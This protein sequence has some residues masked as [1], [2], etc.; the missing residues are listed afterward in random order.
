M[1][2]IYSDGAK[3]IAYRPFKVHGQW[4]G[5]P[6]S[7][8]LFSK[9]TPHVKINVRL[10]VREA[11]PELDSARLRT[12]NRP[13]EPFQCQLKLGLAGGLEKKSPGFESLLVGLTAKQN[14]TSAV[15]FD[16]VRKK[17]RRT[18][19]GVMSSLR[20]PLCQSDPDIIAIVDPT[21]FFAAQDEG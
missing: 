7:C 17:R 5:V 9:G 6:D 16:L 21:D 18:L 15:T 20:L 12:R 11:D 4:N 19:V 3:N 8:P 10:I 2:I 14:L 1:N 13:V